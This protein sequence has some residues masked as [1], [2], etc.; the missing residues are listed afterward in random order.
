MNTFG[1]ILDILEFES[2]PFEI[3]AKRGTLQPEHPSLRRREGCDGCVALVTS[4]CRP[5]RALACVLAHISEIISLY[6]LLGISPNLYFTEPRF[7]KLNS[8]FRSLGKGYRPKYGV[9]IQG[10]RNVLLF[11]LIWLT[12]KWLTNRGI[13]TSAR[14][15]IWQLTTTFP[16]HGSSGCH[17]RQNSKISYDSLE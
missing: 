16:R 3:L 15:R 6:L 1:I 5:K 11:K 2:S 14:A 17:G 13:K 7:G 10:I 8:E 4:S 12:S 9:A